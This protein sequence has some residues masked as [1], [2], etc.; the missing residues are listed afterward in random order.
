MAQGLFLHKY[1]TKAKLYSVT[2]S[3]G[4]TNDDNKLAN[5]ARVKALALVKASNL[6]DLADAATARTNLGVA[7][8]SD[9]QA[10]DAELDALAALT[11]AA[12]KGIQFTGSG[13]AA[14]YDLT[15]AGKALLDD[16]DAAA[17]RVTMGVEIGVDV[18]AYDPQLADIAGLSPTD[19]SF[20]VGDGSNFVLESGATARSSLGLGSMA[21]QNSGSVSISGGAIAG[22]TDLAVADGGTGAS[23]AADA[24]TNLGLAIGSDV[25]AYDDQLADIA[26]LTPTDGNIIIGNGTNF[27]LESGATARASLGLTIGTNVQAFDDQLAD[28]AA[29]SLSDGDFLVGDGSGAIVAESGATV[30]T[31][32]GLG[33]GDSP[34]F[35]SI[36]LSGQSAALAMNSQKITGLADPT[37]AQD[38]ATKAYV[39]GVKQGLDIKESVK[40]ATT[41]SGTLASSFANG[42]TVDG[43]TLATGDRILIKDQSTASEN[44][45]YTVNASGAP[46]RAADFD[47]AADVTSGAFLFVEQG[48]T[49]ADSGFVLTTDGG[50][51]GPDTSSRYTGFDALFGSA[52][53][54]DQTG[55]ALDSTTYTTTSASISFTTDA[56]CT[57]IGDTI[58][59][60]S[61]LIF[62]DASGDTI[63]YRINGFTIQ[64]GFQSVSTVSGSNLIYER[65]QSTVET[66]NSSDVTAMSFKTQTQVGLKMTINQTGLTHETTSIFLE[67][68]FSWNGGSVPAGKYIE[69][70]DSGN[71]LYYKT[72][73]ALANGDAAISVEADVSS[74]DASTW[75]I[76]PGPGGPSMN[77]FDAGLSVVTPGTSDLTFTQFSGAGQLTAGDGI[78]KSGNTI[79]ADL[80]ANGGVV[81]ESSE[82]AVD[83]SASSI[84]G[85]LAVGDGGTGATS[86]SAAR[87]ALGLAIGSDVQ[88]YDDQLADIAALSPTDA[89]FIVGD[90]SNF[91]LE[92]GATARSSLGLVIGTDVQAHDPQ[93]AD[94]AG[95]T[96]AD[97]AFIVGDGSNFVAE[98]GSTARNSLGLNKGKASD[99]GV[100]LSGDAIKTGS[101]IV[102]PVNFAALLPQYVFDMSSETA[103]KTFTLPSSVGATAGAIVGIKIKGDMGSGASLVI[104]APTAS[105]GGGQ[106]QIENA[107]GK[108]ASLTLDGSYQSVKL[109][110]VEAHDDSS[111]AIHCWSV[112][113]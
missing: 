8:G 59:E 60:N 43:V 108:G 102:S 76:F 80:K 25:Q 62:A 92:S 38:A 39:D 77:F 21:T 28:I 53:S 98:S 37:D 100:D 7:I 23:S 103:A 42:Q 50:A 30:R 65:G 31:S 32:L 70:T 68:G 82:L 47:S 49:N 48:S 35:T 74:S 84:T 109:M 3:G 11:S 107:S 105:G 112:I 22:I 17:Q 26:G 88:A 75:N 5:E 34:A 24:R 94:V 33:T 51:G 10:H 9:V 111:S 79:S 61:I 64:N 6:S 20:I 63:A 13:S 99:M 12:D 46:T 71:K 15:A 104:A 56:S 97:G 14:T 110:L 27:V 44:G 58:P 29:L 113:D 101:T 67:G 90:G 4:L 83:L 16:A 95:L 87:T 36:S 54:I 73:S 40:V 18:Q 81:I 55:L 2:E 78:Q 106:E 41:A 85:T 66:M 91:V 52:T 72:S 86:A 69:F 96:P 45:V 93:L 19:A 1:D 89:H 57:S